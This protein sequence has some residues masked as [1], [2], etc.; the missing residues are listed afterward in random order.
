VFKLIRLLIAFVFFLPVL[1]FADRLSAKAIGCEDLL[2]VTIVKIEPSGAVI[3]DLD[4]GLGLRG[5]LGSAP[6]YNAK[7]A[8]MAGRQGVSYWAHSFAVFPNLEA[9]REHDHQFNETSKTN[10]IISNENVSFLR[11]D[12]PASL[13]QPLFVKLF[14]S[15]EVV[16]FED[17]RDSTGKK[18][19]AENALIHYMDKGFATKLID[20]TTFQ[21]FT[22]DDRG[23][24]FISAGWTFTKKRGVSIYDHVFARDKKGT[25]ISRDVRRLIRRAQ[26]LIKEGGRI[27]FNEN[28]LEA[29]NMARDQYRLG[30]D[31]KKV[32]NSRLIDDPE[33]YAGMLEMNKLGNAF[34]TEVREASGKLIAGVISTRAGNIFKGD[35]IFYETPRPPQE[36]ESAET[37]NIKNRAD[38][39]KMAALL[40]TIRLNR[41]GIG[42][43]DVGM[44]TETSAKLGCI[45][46]S[47]A[48]FA[49]EVVKLNQIPFVEIEFG[50]PIELDEI[51]PVE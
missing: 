10:Y 12:S 21:Y 29:L 13:V 42:I 2:G 36:G 14:N 44:V 47:S 49:A 8:E 20:A 26:N 6:A 16:Y 31:G 3:F 45:Y 37:E 30:N 48:Q 50:R 7:S 9:A 25:I 33:L 40:V 22:Q 1:T 4:K 32:Q 23:P 38:D 34:S 15:S 18:L 35:T 39:A 24:R 19:P 41:Y 11:D 46:V 28:F 51:P 17:V 5:F 27:T 43:S